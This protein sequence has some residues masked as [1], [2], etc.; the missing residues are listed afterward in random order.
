METHALEQ[1]LEFIKSVCREEEKSR[2]EGSL[3]KIGLWPIGQPAKKR[4]ISA[5]I[6]AASSQVNTFFE[7]FLIN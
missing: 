5:V 3:E 1:S 4:K 6:G 2:S 7:K